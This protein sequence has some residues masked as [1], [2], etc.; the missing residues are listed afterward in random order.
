MECRIF[1][2]VDCTYETAYPKAAPDSNLIKLLRGVRGVEPDKDYTKEEVRAG[3][4]NLLDSNLDNL[5]LL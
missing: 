5:T 2:D 1:I 4:C 3:F